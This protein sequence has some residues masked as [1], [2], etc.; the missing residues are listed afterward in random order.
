MD[1]I[2]TNVGLFEIEALIT[3]AKFKEANWRM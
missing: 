2:F 3:N 1:H